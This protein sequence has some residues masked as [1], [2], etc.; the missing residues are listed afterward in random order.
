MRCP[1]CQHAVPEGHF[2]CPSC[3]ISIYSYV[4]E[5]AQFKGGRLERAGKRLL[6]LL[7]VLLLIGA[8]IVLARTIKW[9]EVVNGFKPVAEVS[10]SA[11]PEREAASSSGKRRTASAS[12]QGA[13]ET[14]TKSSKPASAESGNDLKQKTEEPASTDKTRPTP[15]PASTTPTPAKK[16]PNSIK[17]S[18]Q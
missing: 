2:Y 14:P 11:K 9:K 4:P 6:D 7:L 8:G 16:D 5:G 17:Q 3:R 18:Q 13:P 12:A 1:S 15:K 10:P